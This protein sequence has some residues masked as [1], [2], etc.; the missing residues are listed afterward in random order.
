MN[1]IYELIR[2]KH[3]IIFVEH[4]FPVRLYKNLTFL[5]VTY[6]FV[7]GFFRLQQAVFPPGF[8]KFNRNKILV[9]ENFSKL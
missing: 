1:I 6:P 8:P 7:P 4:K 3:T 9:S 2:I 5:T